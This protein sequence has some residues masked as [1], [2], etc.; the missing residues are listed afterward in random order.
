M[1]Q[2][3]DN[4]KKMYYVEPRL[5]KGLEIL[6]VITDRPLY[7][8]VN[9]AIRDLLLKYQNEIKIGGIDLFGINPLNESSE[10]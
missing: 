3:K 7:D 9:E 10:K 4:K 5:E 1:G 2:S 6:K 8:L